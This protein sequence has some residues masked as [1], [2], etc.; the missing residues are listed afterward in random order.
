MGKLSFREVRQ[1]RRFMI[2]VLPCSVELPAMQAW[3]KAALA[4]PWR[5]AGHEAEARAAG[6]VIEDLRRDLP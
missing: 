4:E 3:Y 5:E 6:T 1:G 2:R